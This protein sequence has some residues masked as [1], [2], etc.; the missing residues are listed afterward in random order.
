VFYNVW[1]QIEESNLKGL[2]EEELLLCVQLVMN[3]TMR[4]VNEEIPHPRLKGVT[5]ADILKGIDKGK[6]EINRRYLE[7]EQEKKEVIKPW[8]C[9]DWGFV[10][11]HLFKGTISNLELMTK[12][13]FFLKQP[14][15]KLS[16]LEWNVLGN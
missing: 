4:R 15:R 14:L 7:K 6:I 10:R 11:K 13:C 2:E 3:E 16:K 12:F 5:P 8:N 1:A 9:K